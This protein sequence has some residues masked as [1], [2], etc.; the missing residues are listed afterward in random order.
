MNIERIQQLRDF[1]AG[2][3]PEKLNMHD[4]FTHLGDLVAWVPDMPTYPDVVNE[5]GTCA[6]IAGWANFIFR[7]VPTSRDDFGSSA[8]N[9]LGLSDEQGQLLF[10]ALDYEGHDLIPDIRMI[11]LTHAIAA[12]DIIIAEQ[13]VPDD[14]WQRAG[15]PAVI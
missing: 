12:L 7:D 11:T 2:L 15:L 6:C 3:P 5:C 8:R 10:M 4:W 9:L 13:V 1:L 14:L